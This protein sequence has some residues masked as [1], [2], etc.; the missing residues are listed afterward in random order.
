MYD[1][2]YIVNIAVGG[3]PLRWWLSTALTT[4]YYKNVPRGEDNFPYQH[5]RL[6]E[7]IEFAV[8]KS[9]KFKFNFTH[10][11]MDEGEADASSSTLPAD[12]KAQFAQFKNEIKNLG[13]D[14]PVYMSK[15]S[16]TPSA[17]TNSTMIN[18]QQE[19]INTYV[20]VYNGPNTD[21]YIAGYRWDTLHFNVAGLD[22]IGKDWGNA[23][24]SQEKLLEPIA[25]EF[26][27]NTSTYELSLNI[28]DYN[29]IATDITIV[30][31]KG[32]IWTGTESLLTSNVV[33][34]EFLRKKKS[35]L[36][37]IYYY[38]GD[39]AIKD[40]YDVTLTDENDQPLEGY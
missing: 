33:Q 24:V 19:I 36:P 40:Q 20:D 7:R 34:A 30:Q 16:Y 17:L 27:I 21:N 1:N 6:F 2:V 9:K 39:A 10:V 32:Q 35:L 18:T 15:T 22:A 8:N 11:F 5:N 38:G 29:G 4:D 23:V 12:Y 26:S 13:I 14:A 3:V 37:D 25:P 31:K 28:L